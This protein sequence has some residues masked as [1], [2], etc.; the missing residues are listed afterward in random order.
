M[1]E[2]ILL[3][4]I[5][6][7][8]QNL[9]NWKVF[10]CKFVVIH[11]LILL[12]II[13]IICIWHFGSDEAFLFK[14]LVCVVVFFQ[15]MRDLHMII[16]HPRTANRLL[17]GVFLVY[18][19]NTLGVLYIRCGE[20]TSITK[21]NLDVGRTRTRNPVFPIYNAKRLA[22]AAGNVSPSL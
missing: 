21:I 12:V 20:A 7:S 22:I 17:W 2:T 9:L 19:I 4:E 6:S 1:F 3:N 16:S 8:D 5:T 11:F 14:F 18:A 15:Q 13:V 10:I